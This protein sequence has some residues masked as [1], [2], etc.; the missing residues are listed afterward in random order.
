MET[1][2]RIDLEAALKSGESIVLELGCGA[3]KTKGRIGVDCVD[4]PGVDIVTDLEAGLSFLPD[5]SVDEIHAEHL[6]EHLQNLEG[7]IREVVRVLKPGGTCR[8]RVPHFTNPYACS[9]YTHMRFFGLYTFYYFVDEAHQLS[10]K[11][12]SFYT[13]IRIRVLSQK[14]VFRHPGKIRG[15]FR[16]LYGR[17][18]NRSSAA[19]ERYESSPWKRVPCHAIEVVFTPQ[20]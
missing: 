9:D 19:Q 8:V 13:D 16:K 1:E 7:M 17:W 2:I 15:P 20:K 4:L 3:K 6:F 5:N 18:V 10:R 14:L 12:P 11:V